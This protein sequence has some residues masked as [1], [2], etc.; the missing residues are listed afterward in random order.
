MVPMEARNWTPGQA[1][2]GR[3]NDETRIIFSP[4]KFEI[5]A[6]SG[7]PRLIFPRLLPYLVS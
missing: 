3:M 2:N 7:E 1:L 5:S 4:A 6:K